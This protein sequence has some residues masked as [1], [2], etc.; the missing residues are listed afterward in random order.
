MA[1][2]GP[3][4][5]EL[6]AE[7]KSGKV[8][9]VYLL[10]GE[11]DFLVDQAL[12][13]ILDAALGGGDRG[14]NLDVMR[15]GDDD[16]RDIIAR[17]SSFPMMADRRVVV[18]RDADK[19]SG[20]EPEFVASYVDHPLSS[21]CLVLVA[22]KPDFRKKPFSTLRKAGGAVEF[23]RLYDN[24]VSS[25]ITDR[26]RQAGRRIEPEAAKLLAAYA[27]TS[28]REVNNELDKLSILAGDQKEITE[29]DVSAVVGMSR[30]F[31]IFELQR[32]L[33]RRQTARAVSIIDRMLGAG[34]RVPA[35]IA[36][37]T[38]YFVTLW[39]LHDMRRRGVSP[40]DQAAVARVNPF[41]MKEYIEALEAT[42]AADCERA[43]LHL[44]QVDEV[45]KSSSMD[46]RQVMLT[47]VIR[48]CGADG[49]PQEETSRNL[50]PGAEV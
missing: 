50:T 2:S 6:E 16:A 3:T 45:T 46:T 44:A 39:K 4:Y 8:L 18:V 49:A 23:K 37:L 25:W 24:Q 14:F 27:G 26:L 33:G 7:L 28:L 22:T 47:M 9:P 13:G 48:L 19:M 31:S 21:T 34:E 36:S 11:E 1:K 10:Y 29:D 15:G 41:F 17:A 20:R 40:G 43:F 35:I 5:A 38:T 42:T 12:G 32:A 30:E